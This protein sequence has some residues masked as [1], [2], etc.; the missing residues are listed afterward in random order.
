MLGVRKHSDVEKKGGIHKL[1][2]A[3][4]VYYPQDNEYEYTLPMFSSDM[5]EVLGR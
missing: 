1:Y 5:G 3:F 4:L 2:G